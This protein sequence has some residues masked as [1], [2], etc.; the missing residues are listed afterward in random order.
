MVRTLNNKEKTNEQLLKENL[1][2]RQQLIELQA[3]T[4]LLKKAEQEK[5]NAQNYLESIVDTVREPLVI[6]DKY[7]QVISANKSF[8]Q[9]NRR[10][11]ESKFREIRG[12]I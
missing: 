3:S 12:Y 4:D 11:D 6:L 5:K 8:Y 7:L 9:K 2:L 10:I 1:Q